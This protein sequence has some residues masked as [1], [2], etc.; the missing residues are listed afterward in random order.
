[1]WSY[2]APGESN[3]SNRFHIFEAKNGVWDVSWGTTSTVNTTDYDDY[4]AFVE[5]T[6]TAPISDLAPFAWQHAL[7][8]YDLSGAN[9][10]VSVYINGSS[11]PVVATDTSGTFSFAGLNIG[12]HRDT[13]G[14]RDWD[15]MLDEFAIWNRALTEE[16]RTEVYTKGSIG[17]P[18]IT[19]SLLYVEISALDPSTGSVTGAGAFQS[20]QE[21]SIAAIPEPGY[22]FSEW[23][24]DFAGQPASFTY[25]VTAD[26]SASAV[27][28]QDT[29]DDDADG[30][31]NYEE[32]VQIGSS[33][34]NSDTDGDG[35]PDGDEWSL[36]FTD[37]LVDDSA[38][39]AFVRENL[40]E[41]AAGVIQLNPPGISTDPTTGDVT[42]S[43]SFSGSANQEN[44]IPLTPQSVTPVQNGW[45]V[46]LPAPSSSVNSY[47][48]KT[49][50]P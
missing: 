46:T 16:E 3:G 2:L 31:S 18:I 13:S 7:L 17:A 49:Q 32:V 41:S 40:C 1:V 22:L 23:I 6:S 10:T 47:I 20:G 34:D 38:L 30:L 39:I 42:L 35:I 33:P 43:L 45:E 29:N 44:L 27:F 8:E 48:L 24:G 9:P 37:P 14:D 19:P 21:A 50:Y 4:A 11:T 36:S 5:T 12:R 25:N 15:G 26:V 28:G